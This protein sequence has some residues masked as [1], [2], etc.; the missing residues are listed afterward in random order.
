MLVLLCIQVVQINNNESNWI[1]KEKKN[2][3]LLQ[4]NKKKC[5]LATKAKNFN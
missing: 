5:E 3:F 2:N 4:T 1:R